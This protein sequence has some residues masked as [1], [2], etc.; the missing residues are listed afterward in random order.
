MYYK[1][2]Y[3]DFFNL[4]NEFSNE[5]ITFEFM[6]NI[7]ESFDKIPKERHHTRYFSDE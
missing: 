5:N 3:E 7:N 4:K 1:G 6:E 2:F